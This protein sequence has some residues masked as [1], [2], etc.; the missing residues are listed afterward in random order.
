M[1]TQTEAMEPLELGM[2]LSCKIVGKWKSKQVLKSNQ[3]S[4]I[5]QTQLGVKY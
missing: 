2:F 4:Q 5:T 3:F 1:R